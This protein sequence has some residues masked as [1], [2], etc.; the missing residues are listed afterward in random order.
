M[1]TT[2]QT[3]KR[4]PETIESYD[5]IE[6][7]LVAAFADKTLPREIRDA[8]KGL[9]REREAFNEWYGIDGNHLVDEREVHAVLGAANEAEMHVVLALR[10][11]REPGG[12]LAVGL[13]IQD[14]V[15]AY[16]DTIR[17]AVPPGERF[18][19]RK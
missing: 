9:E 2:K 18:S 19:D 16:S 11:L 14:C 8:L 17:R 7:G 6:A 13:R 10:H 3:A 4:K 1:A 5:E 12:A 15:E